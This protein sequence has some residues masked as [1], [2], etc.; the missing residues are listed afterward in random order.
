MKNKRKLVFIDEELA[1]LVMSRMNYLK[2]TAAQ[3]AKRLRI[4]YGT[5]VQAKT[6]GKMNPV[7]RRKLKRWVSK[8]LNTKKGEK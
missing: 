4:K 3:V 2:L 1:G 8:P 5:F 6:Y 7:V